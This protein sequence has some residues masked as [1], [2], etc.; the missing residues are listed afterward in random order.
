VKHGSSAS[1]SS[2]LYT[3]IALYLKGRNRELLLFL[4]YT[5]HFRFFQNLREPKITR[6]RTTFHGTQH[7]DIHQLISRSS[8]DIHLESDVLLVGSQDLRRGP[9]TPKSQFW[10]CNFRS[11]LSA[12]P[13][14]CRPVSSVL[15]S[16]PK[17]HRP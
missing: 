7:A 14:L 6:I 17:D 13:L 3:A 8:A 4:C 16:F 1:G 12:L 5:R 15:C 2:V 11:V 9:P 10:F